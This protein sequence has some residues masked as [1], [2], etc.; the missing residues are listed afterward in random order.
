MECLRGSSLALGRGPTASLGLPR[1][2]AALHVEDV[3]VDGAVLDGLGVGAQQVDQREGKGV[4]KRR[5]LASDDVAIT[6]D[7]RI[8][9]RAGVFDLVTHTGIAGKLPA[10][11]QS[12]ATERLGRGTDGADPSTAIAGCTQGGNELVAVAHGVGAAVATGQHHHVV[13]VERAVEHGVAAYGDVMGAGNI[14]GAKAHHVDLDLRTAQHVDDREG[15][16]L[17]ASR[18]RDERHLCHDASFPRGR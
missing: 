7:R 3:V 18:S 16:A 14:L 11:E 17:L 9:P 13:R 2:N 6:H 12:G 10:L 4:G 1:G 5:T 8:D 15:L